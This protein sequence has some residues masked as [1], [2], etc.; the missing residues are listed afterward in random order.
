LEIPSSNRVVL[1]AFAANLAI[2][3]FKFIAAAFT[4]SAS[5]LSEGIHSVVDTAD[6]LLLLWGKRR[7]LKPAD[8]A[9]PF[10]YGME[11]YFWS[12]IVAILLF[13]MGGGMSIYEGITHIR[14]PVPMENA[15]WNYA[16]LAF[17]FLAESFSFR[18]AFRRFQ[19]FRGERGVWTAFHGSKNPAVFVSLAED[20][21]ALLGL[22]VATAGIVSSHLL[23]M[24]ILD[25]IG[26]IVIG[27]ILASVATLLAIESRAL[28]LGE[29]TSPEI[30]QGVRKLALE[31][32]GVTGVGPLLTMHFG[33]DQILLNMQIGFRRGMPA[34]EIVGTIEALKGKLAKAYPRIRRVFIEA[35]SLE[36]DG[37]AAEVRIRGGTIL[38]G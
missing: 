9:H 35:G 2:A 27:G 15:A 10:G 26:S 33:P 14:H 6:Q 18:V 34:E 23:G 25:G 28:L 4:G 12:L 32:K 3:T 7:S 5:I 16:V 19:S 37:N 8:E 38:A 21:A 31:E 22:V 30:V 13:A 29:S 11:Y 24:P 20:S 17:A 36:A 1:S